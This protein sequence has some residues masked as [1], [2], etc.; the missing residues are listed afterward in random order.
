MTCLLLNVTRIST[1]SKSKVKLPKYLELT[2]SY[3]PSKA[4]VASL[5]K[6]SGQRLLIK[7]GTKIG[8][9]FV[10]ETFT[11]ATF[12]VAIVAYLNEL[13]HLSFLKCAI[14][15]ATED[16]NPNP[17]EESEK[18][19]RFTT[20][21]K[22]VIIAGVAVTLV[23][24]AGLWV[25]IEP[26]SFYF[27]AGKIYT[28]IVTI[29]GY[30]KWIQFS[31]KDD[32]GD[33]TDLFGNDQQQNKES[34]HSGDSSQAPQSS[35]GDSGQAPQSSSKQNDGVEESKSSSVE[36]DIEKIARERTNQNIDRVL[37]AHPKIIELQQAF[38]KLE[39]QYYEECSAP[40]G[41]SQE[42]KEKYSSLLNGL[43]DKREQWA[44]MLKNK[45]YEKFV[46]EEKQNRGL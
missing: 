21:K 37:S 4:K 46:A 26:V 7:Q 13:D 28:G 29:G 44:D 9:T 6:T 10:V 20:R 15:E 34:P 3:F 41:I 5:V 19:S 22:V 14:I 39:R 17:A 32:A 8:I 30:F 12:F 23:F 18:P 31:G 11:G 16:S 43:R 1:W 40:G 25:C 36:L 27:V 24:V 38:E 45:L 33:S 35:T 42:R 2:K